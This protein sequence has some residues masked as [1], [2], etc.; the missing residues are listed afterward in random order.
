MRIGRKAFIVGL[1]V[2]AAAIAIASMV[3]SSPVA[4]QQRGMMAST[5]MPLP[6]IGPA[7]VPTTLPYPAYGTP[8]PG[9]E[10]T[11]TAPG[12]PQVIT[13]PQAIAVAF[14]RSPLLASARAD[15]D[16]AKVEVRLQESGYLPD[17]AGTAST[18]HSNSQGGSVPV[19]SPSGA[20]TTATTGGSYTSNSLSVSLRQLIF[21]GGKVAAAIRSAQRSEVAQV[22]TYRRTMQTVAYNVAQ[23][24]YTALAAERTVAVD[25]EVVHENTVAEDLV[26]AQ[27]NAGTV[28][29]SDV[30][31][32][33]FPVAQARVA[34]V[35][36][37][38]SQLSAQAAF[39]N[40]MGID[41]NTNVLPADDTPIFTQSAIQ[42]VPVPTYA[43]AIA[44]ATD[45]RPDYDAAVQAVEAARL[46]LVSARRAYIPSVSGT[47]EDGTSSTSPTGGDF[48]NSNELGLE[49]SVPIYDQ[50]IL[51]ADVAQAQA[52]LDSANAAFL[53]TQ[54]GMQLNVKEALVNFISAQSAVTQANAE[55]S[56]AL[57]VFQS[58]Q[59]QYRAGVTTL[60]LLLDAEVSLTTALTDQVTTVYSLR[61][62][63][64]AFLYAEGENDQQPTRTSYVR[65][66]SRF[67]HDV[68][69]TAPKRHG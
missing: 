22:D 17:I 6:S 8:A 3:V 54:E 42:T 10:S 27:A 66:A 61:Q 1:S 38:G 40:S 11:A 29:R 16:L 51:R 46:S 9:V 32:A 44:R 52:N 4:A 30:A 19:T 28:A 37:Q 64:Q 68:A 26:Q 33:A 20:P 21:D 15:V 56:E 25:V 69:I 31:T 7:S 43:Q 23:A 13:L 2:L 63:E 35:Q 58:T 62:A 14:A 47:A 67:P 65:V 36:A 55:Y 41:A 45:L 57:V 48:R 60:P 49:L 53:T 24:Y 18:T 59:A 5:P 34:L 50:G 39:A 12:V